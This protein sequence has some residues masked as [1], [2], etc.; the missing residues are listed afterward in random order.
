M[1]FLLGST[2]CL[3]VPPESEFL[4]VLIVD[5]FRINEDYES[6]CKFDRLNFTIKIQTLY[7]SVQ[8][9]CVNVSKPSLIQKVYTCYDSHYLLIFQ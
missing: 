1:A 7:S 4:K 6:G 5:L 2:V 9:F 3:S 8:V